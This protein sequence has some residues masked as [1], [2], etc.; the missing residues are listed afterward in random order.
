[1]SAPYWIPLHVSD[2]LRDTRHLSTV[3]HGAYLLLLMTAWT[4]EGELPADEKRLH[5]ITGLTRK[6]WAESR[7]ILLDFFTLGDG[8]YRHKRIDEDLAKAGALIEKKRAAGKASAAARAAE[9]ERNRRSTPVGT[10]V[11][12]P[13]P[14]DGQQTGNKKQ[15]QGSSS[16]EEAAAPPKSIW[17]TGVAFLT[18]KGCNPGRARSL[19]GSWRRDYGEQAVGVALAEAERLDVSDPPPWIAA[20]LAKGV[21]DNNALFA[22]IERT[23]G[24]AGGE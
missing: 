13:V 20:R 22:S 17:E 16:K 8:T 12:T 2:Y 3:E 21:N 11:P 18:S 5:R 15:K 24:G 4:S 7:D 6:E 1:M 9:R 10:P 19:I 14:T 23:F